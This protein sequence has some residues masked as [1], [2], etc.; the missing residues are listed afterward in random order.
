MIERID[1]VLSSDTFGW[2]VIVAFVVVIGANV[3]RSM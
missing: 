1:E 3:V 2:A